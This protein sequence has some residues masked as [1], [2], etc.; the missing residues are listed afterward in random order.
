MSQPAKAASHRRWFVSGVR[1]KAKAER[2]LAVS[3]LS[4]QLRFGEEN[5]LI[6]QPLWATGDGNQRSGP[7]RLRLKLG[8]TASGTKTGQ[9]PKS[10]FKKAAASAS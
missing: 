3:R 6:P 4:R 1:R 2:S 7:H 5:P 10:P 9:G 8:P